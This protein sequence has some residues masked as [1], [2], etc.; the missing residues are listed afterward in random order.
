MLTKTPVRILLVE[1]D[2]IDRESVNRALRQSGL[3]YHL[4]ETADG[5]SALEA[6]TNGAYD[7]VLLDYH[8]P[9]QSGI[10]TFHAMTRV[11]GTT[12]AVIF[13]T[14]EDNEELALTVMESGAVDYLN[15]NELTPAMLRRSIRYAQARQNFLSVLADLGRRDA[16]TG[17]PNRAVFDD[18]LSNA[19]AQSNRQETIVATLLLDLDHFKD[20]NDTLGHPAGDEMLRIIAERL[21]QSTRKSD[22]V[23]RLGG[24]EFIIVAPKSEPI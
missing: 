5:E 21:K 6:F 16:L 19:I 24:D 4:H 23:I 13:L 14:G 22:T 17:L 1:D 18:A 3:K 8:L 12:A 7:C 10:D 2:E 11:P 9:G 20:I 15:K